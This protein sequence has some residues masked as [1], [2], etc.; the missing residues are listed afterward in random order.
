MTAPR[1][2]WLRISSVIV[3]RPVSSSP[4]TVSR[5]EPSTPPACATRSV[6]VARYILGRDNVRLKQLANRAQKTTQARLRRRLHTDARSKS[7]CT[8]PVIRPLL[9]PVSGSRHHDDVAATKKEVLLLAVRRDA[10]TVVEGD[11]SHRLA[12]LSEDRYPRR[13]GEVGEA[14]GHG[15]GVE[16]G[17]ASSQ[18]VSARP[19]DL[20]HH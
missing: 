12:L 2:V 8:A 7:P 18:R 15:D 4:V 16:D 20:A 19:P 17:G 6:A 3:Y 1:R 9:L 14:P 10:L 5:P 13:R 11:P